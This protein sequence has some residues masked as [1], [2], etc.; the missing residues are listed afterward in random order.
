MIGGSN[1]IRSEMMH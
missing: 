1:I